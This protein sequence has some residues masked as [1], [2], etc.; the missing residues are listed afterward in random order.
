MFQVYD[1]A[2]INFFQRKIKFLSYFKKINIL[3]WDM[4]LDLQRISDLD[5]SS[6]TLL[7][8]KWTKIL[9]TNSVHQKTMTHLLLYRVLNV[10]P[11]FFETDVTRLIEL[12]I[13]SRLFLQKYQFVSIGKSNIYSDNKL[14]LK[15]QVKVYECCFLQYKWFYVLYCVVT[16]LFV[17]QLDRINFILHFCISCI[18]MYLV[19]HIQWI[20]SRS[21]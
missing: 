14:P 12:N 13:K 4:I 2:L 19:G 5:I 6:G 18:A 3:D 16:N 8:V 21:K 9:R 15:N 20:F 10:S 7:W 11:F 1:F 17:L